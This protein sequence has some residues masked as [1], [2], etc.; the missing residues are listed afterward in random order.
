MSAPAIQTRDAQ[1]ARTSDSPAMTRLR[2]TR[3]TLIATV[4]ARA[5]LSAAAIAA[6]AVLAWRL[7]VRVGG[8]TSAAPLVDAR[9]GIAIVFVGALGVLLMRGRVRTSMESAAL[10]VETRVP[11]LHY[12]LVTLLDQP[13]PALEQRV[14][15]AR[16]NDALRH[17]AQRALWPPA[18]ALVLLASAAALVPESTTA[19][20]SRALGAGNDAAENAA[21]TARVDRLAKL[22]VTIAPPAYSGLAAQTLDDPSA[23]AALE[24]STIAVRGAG[25]ATGL[26]MRID[27]VG[28]AAASSTPRASDVRD[29]WR[30][31]FIMPTRPA[32]LRLSLGERQRL[33]VL[34]PRADSL[35][36]VTLIAPARDTVLRAPNGILALAAHASDDLGLAS[37]AFEYIVSSGEGE[38]FTFRSGRVGVV[39]AAGAR[40]QTLGARLTLDSLVLKPG[41]I[42][43]LRAVARDRNPAAERV[44]GASETRTLRIARAGEY[45]SLAVEGAPPPDA[46]KSVLSQRM[47]L[48][49]TEALEKRRPRITKPVLV[50]ESRRIAVDQARLRR[51]VSDIIFSRLDGSAEGEHS[52]GEGDDHFSGDGHAHGDDAKVK[53]LTPEELLAAASRA[54]GSGQPTVLDFAGGESP[55]VNV[56]K[57]L[58][59]AYNH[60]WDAG[61]A[62]DVGEPARAIPPMRLALAAI[63]RART[64]ERIC[65]AVR[66]TP[67][68]GPGDPPVTVTVSVGVAVFPGHGEASPSLLRAADKAL[69][70]AKRGGRDGWRLAPTPAAAPAP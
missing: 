44:A 40:R 37:A 59:E 3:R 8:V 54:T 58:L 50:A 29:G 35:P 18:L 45:D 60:M 46:D 14:R 9:L 52:H 6:A 61:R 7:W 24:G 38:S 63:Q 20:L 30:A 5:T 15:G 55:V 12:A 48:M 70:L 32:V 4:I 56:N 23:V 10:W 34:E 65:Q 62:L 66:A 17:A 57:P 22:R 41:D 27:A 19:A 21:P 31:V 47:L 2:A 39:N 67:F 28:D 36:S 11:E 33:L 68:G 26:T 42:V 69:Y 51:Q 64:A 49:L 25:D 16:W 1:S 13:S 43:H 53:T